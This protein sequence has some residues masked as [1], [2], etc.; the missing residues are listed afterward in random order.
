MEHYS[1]HFCQDSKIL[2]SLR[3]YQ[4]TGTSKVDDMLYSPAFLENYETDYY[5]YLNCDKFFIDA[6]E[7]IIGLNHDRI[8]D[9]GTF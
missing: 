8:F 3:K 1:V 9:N 2:L 7:A 5:S 4:C 6:T